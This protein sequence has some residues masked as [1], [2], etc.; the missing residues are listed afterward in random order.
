MNRP[1]AV[2]ALAIPSK[3]CGWTDA[4]HRVA[5]KDAAKTLRGLTVSC[6]GHTK[7]GH[8]T[9]ER[10]VAWVFLSCSQANVTVLSVTV[11]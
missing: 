2:F 7:F 8:L 3:G 6:V 10:L 1:L 11:N 5:V 4:W 9:E